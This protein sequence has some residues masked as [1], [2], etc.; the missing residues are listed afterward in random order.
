MALVWLPLSSKCSRAAEALGAPGP[1]VDTCP[2]SRPL[3]G[4]EPLAIGVMALPVFIVGGKGNVP[5]NTLMIT[6]FLMMEGNH[7]D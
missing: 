1:A 4:L 7:L 3:A 2:R 5:L 6:L